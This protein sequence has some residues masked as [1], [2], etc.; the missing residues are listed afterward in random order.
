MHENE[1]EFHRKIVMS[2]E[3]P[4]HRPRRKNRCTANPY[5]RR[6]TVPVVTRE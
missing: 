3:A 2:D 1:P 5:N 6:G 4:L